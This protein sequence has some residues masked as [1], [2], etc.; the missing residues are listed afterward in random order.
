MKFEHTEV[1]GFKH[2][3]RGM[4][5]PK[6]SW[7]KSDSGEVC[8]NPGDVELGGHPIM[9]FNIGPNDMKLAQQL[10]RAGSEHRKFMRQ[11][12]VSVDIT[13]P[14]F[15]WSEF[16]TYKVGTVANSTS[17]MH[18][19][20]SR[21]ITGDC[22]ETGDYDPHLIVKDECG[23]GHE[24]GLW[25]EGFTHFL[26]YLRT[27]FL[28]TK[29]KTYWKE[30]IRWLPESWLQTRTV[31][32]NYE[33]LLAICSKGQRRFHKLG[34]WSKEFIAWARTLPYAQELIFV[35]EIP[36]NSKSL[37]VISISGKAGAG[38]DTLGQV[39]KQKMEAQGYSVLVTHY[40]DLLKYICK[41]FF[42]WNGEKDEAGRSLL[43]YVGTDVVRKRHPDF[44]V[45]FLIQ[46]FD[47]FGDSWDCVIIPDCRFPN[48]LHRIRE[49]GYHATHIR[50]V[51]DI[52][53]GLSE[54]Q[55]QH[56]SE[57][58]MDNEIPDFIV[59]NNGTVEDLF[60][61]VEVVVE[62]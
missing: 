16:D 61:A 20:A 42:D 37:R 35:D 53:S 43:Q 25:T 40:A 19:I 56:A 13:A 54:G 48:E 36:A 11:I 4:R 50:V 46:I 51:R 32:M 9:G 23:A 12:F 18:K 59:P 62:S 41:T 7:E 3:L 55:Q 39:I 2:A 30:L 58:A 29:D 22:F 1:W 47:L 27:G 6:E 5:N 8:L 52:E 15:W 10:I 31:T 21:P 33:N 57:T 60:S 45:D 44:W 49:A 17:K 26:E 14:Q 38:K 24:V 34:E 28:K